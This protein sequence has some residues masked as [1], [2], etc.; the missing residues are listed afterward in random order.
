[1][2]Y[3]AAKQIWKV[4]IPDAETFRDRKAHQ[5]VVDAADGR[6]SDYFIWD[7]ETRETL[8]KRTGGAQ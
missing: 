3:L 6:S 7:E 4:R 2:E 1:M 5:G 8:R